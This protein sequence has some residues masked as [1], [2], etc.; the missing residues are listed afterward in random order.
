MGMGNL[1]G[2][3]EVVGREHVSMEFLK[4]VVWGGNGKRAGGDDNIK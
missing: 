4:V 2:C 1:D 3:V